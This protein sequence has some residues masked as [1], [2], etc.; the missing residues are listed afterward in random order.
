MHRLLMPAPSFKQPDST[1]GKY[2]RLTL[3]YWLV[4]NE[5]EMLTRPKQMKEEQ[6]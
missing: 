4:K 3:P 5:L 6:L 1:K 2:W